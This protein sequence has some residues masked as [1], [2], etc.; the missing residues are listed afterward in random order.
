MNL[1]L[2]DY[3]ITLSSGGARLGLKNI[4]AFQS[5][6]KSSSLFVHLTLFMS[7]FFH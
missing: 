6:Q 1:V 3:V 5:S 4:I 2:I 7:F